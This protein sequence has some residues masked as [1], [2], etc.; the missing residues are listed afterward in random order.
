MSVS[1]AAI[2]ASA[3]IILAQ[4][5][6]LASSSSWF[7]IERSSIFSSVFLGNSP[8]IFTTIGDQWNLKHIPSSVREQKHTNFIKS[9]YKSTWV[10][11]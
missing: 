4:K 11:S 3:L 7:G 2:T 8:C 6:N 9:F 10:H 1:F 5:I